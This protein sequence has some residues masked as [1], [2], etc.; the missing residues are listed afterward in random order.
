M[1]KTLLILALS[2]IAPLSFAADVYKIDPVHSGISFKIRHFFSKTPGQFNKFNGT[3][4][5]DEKDPSNSHV[6]ATIDI[7]S[8][9]TNNNDRDEHLKNEDYFNVAVNPKMMFKSTSWEKT[10]ENRFDVVGEL[11]MLGISKSVTLKVELLGIGEG[12][13]HFEGITLS[14]WS[15]TTTID[16]TQWGLTGGAP[17]VGNEVEIELNIEA[18]K[19]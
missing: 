19:K 18:H 16:R 12:Q 5:Y 17:A 1:K 7:S 3:I 2:A 10:G 15:A 4:H 9:D 8:V 14:G 6:E 11:T 13:G